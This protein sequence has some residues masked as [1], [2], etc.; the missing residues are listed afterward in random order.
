MVGR[1]W[2]TSVHDGSN[3]RMDGRED[4]RRR[5]QDLRWGAHPGGA[6]NSLPAA[7][8]E[9]R[10]AARLQ[11]QLD[12]LFLSS[13][14]RS[15]PTCSFGEPRATARSKASCR[16][17]GL[18]AVGTRGTSHGR[19]CT[20]APCFT[21]NAVAGTPAYAGALLNPCTDTVIHNADMCRRVVHLRVGGGLGFGLL[22]TRLTSQ[23]RWQVSVLSVGR[24]SGFGRG[25]CAGVGPAVLRLCCRLLRG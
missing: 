22:W 2:N 10:Q 21:V 23:Q 18:R 12:S 15:P 1:K 24:G 4:R 25:R 9:V 14:P 11:L 20:C 16:P 8:W 6:H 19:H 7:V 5:G 3:R 17:H 13:A